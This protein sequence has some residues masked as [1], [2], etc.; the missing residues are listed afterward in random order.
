MTDDTDADLPTAQFADLVEANRRY[1]GM[2]SGSG[3]RAGLIG[4]AGRGL[5]VVT[6]IDSRIDP[7]AV[8]GLGLGEAKICRNAGAR[9]TDDVLRS[10]VMAV[11]YLGVERI[12]IV[13][14]SDC[15]M[16]SRSEAAVRA[17]LA[18][19]HGVD[20]GSLEFLAGFDQAQAAA[21]DL[22]KLRDCPLIDDSVALAA[23][24]LDLDTGLLRSL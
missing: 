23:F 6:C 3:H 4:G 9:V 18:E 8:L 19:R 2:G 22:Q 15:A 5:G 16:T 14:H 12:C 13:A 24:I 17:E 7:L 21:L 1:G 11:N 20:A 10:L